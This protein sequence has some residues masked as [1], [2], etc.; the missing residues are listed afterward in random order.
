MKTS[1]YRVRMLRTR[2]SE[3][4]LEGMKTAERERSACL[5]ARSEAYL[6]GMKTTGFLV[7][8]AVVEFVRSLPRRNEN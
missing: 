1:Y 2:Q 4:Y 8:P 5:R 7:L 3:A 6:E